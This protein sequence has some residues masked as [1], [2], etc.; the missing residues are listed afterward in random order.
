MLNPSKI[1]CSFNKVVNKIK[2]RY[3]VVTIS[4]LMALTS[5][6]PKNVYAIEGDTLVDFRNLS[7]SAQVLID[8]AKTI[9]PDG[10]VS[11]NI[12]SKDKK[13]MDKKFK[14]LI[15]KL[16]KEVERDIKN[17]DW[18]K[19][20][21]LLG[22]METII[23]S[24]DSKLSRE[25]LELR[26]KVHSDFVSHVD[27]SRP[28]VYTI[29]GS[30]KVYVVSYSSTAS[31][32]MAMRRSGSNARLFLIQYLKI[33]EAIIRGFGQVITRSIRKDG[34]SFQVY[35]L[36]MFVSKDGHIILPDRNVLTEKEIAERL[37]REH[38]FL[39]LK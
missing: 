8:N 10:S 6:T 27:L 37:E 12:C 20:E 34:K 21:Y 26:E 15:K 13:E 3:L 31:M 24:Y 4:T 19:T 18:S 7:K 25:F 33:K 16:K 35:E 5:I 32:S 1:S 2:K 17:Q 22:L 28:G 39:P 11:Y 36:V 23:S 9:N 29:K 14:N 30:G 38:R